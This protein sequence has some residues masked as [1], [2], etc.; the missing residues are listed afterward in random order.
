[1][2][3]VFSCFL[4]KLDFVTLYFSSQSSIEIVEKNA[5]WN[6][7]EKVQVR[8]TGGAA[9][10]KRRRLWTLLNPERV[11]LVGCWMRESGRTRKE[12]KEGTKG[13]V[14]DTRIEFLTTG[15]ELM[16]YANNLVSKTIFQNSSLFSS[17]SCFL[18]PKSS[19]MELLSL[20]YNNCLI[21]LCFVSLKT[22]VCCHLIFQSIRIK[23]PCPLL[24]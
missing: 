7:L 20:Y 19:N 4:P 16:Q 1:M 13:V 10:L 11:V 9:L 3:L 12:G 5:L 22:I 8:K 6:L 14:C 17:L 15:K 23:S 21:L 24:L 18:L 2:R